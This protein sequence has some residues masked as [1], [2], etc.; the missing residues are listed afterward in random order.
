MKKYL[1]YLGPV[2]IT[3][4]FVLAIYLLYHKLKAYSIA[5]IRESIQQVSTGS[6]CFSI[7]L[8]IVNYIILV[9][10]DW[11]ALKA[12]HKSLPLPRVGLVS[13]VG[14]AVSYNF[15]ALQMCIRDS[16]S[17]GRMRLSP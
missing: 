7:G 2:L 11:L 8:M 6:I 12:I 4:L 3:A 9:G 5:Q 10:Y 16:G 15:G 14:Q 13:L 17:A 1:R